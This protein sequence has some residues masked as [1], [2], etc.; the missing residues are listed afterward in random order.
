MDFWVQVGLVFSVLLVLDGLAGLL[1]LDRLEPMLRKLLP[2][3]RLGPIAAA[4]MAGGL[5]CMALILLW[6]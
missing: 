1:F 6:G 3:V 5:V 2:G 4:E